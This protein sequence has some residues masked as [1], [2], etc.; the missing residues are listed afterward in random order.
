SVFRRSLAAALARAIEGLVRAEVGD[1]VDALLFMA[2]KLNDPEHFKILG[3]ASKYPD[4]IA[5]LHH[6][7]SFVRA[8]ASTA[9]PSSHASDESP[10]T[11][12]GLGV[13][14]E[15]GDDLAR[16]LDALHALATALSGE[17]SSR[18]DALRAVLVR[19]SR[20]LT[21][22]QESSSL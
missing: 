18:E 17:N 2:Q 7:E 8:H 21:R 16:R 20:A 14:A 13:R 4:L 3:E 22:V 11:L 15:D 1:A 6:Y 5:L 12:P 10:L 9:R 19:L